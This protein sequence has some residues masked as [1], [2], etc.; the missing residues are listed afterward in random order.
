MIFKKKKLFTFLLKFSCKIFFQKVINLNYFFFENK[1]GKK[2]SIF[3][4][5]KKEIHSLCSYSSFYIVI[6][7]PTKHIR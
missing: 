7:K 5:E 3:I 2:I 1:I 6:N 4:V